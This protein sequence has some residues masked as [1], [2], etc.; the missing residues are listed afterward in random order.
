M[1]NAED[2]LSAAGSD[3]EEPVLLNAG[4]AG[5]H[6]QSDALGLEEQQVPSRLGGVD[7]HVAAPWPIRPR[8]L[9]LGLSLVIR[10][11][12]HALRES[13][14]LAVAAL[15]A[16][17]LGHAAIARMRVAVVLRTCS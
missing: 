10:M 3:L 13:A 12:S 7:S 2:V 9:P 5:E 16:D 8:S 14:A 4:R 6:V 15:V 17:V 11:R 1:G